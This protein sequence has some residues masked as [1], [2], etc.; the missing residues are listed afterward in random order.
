MKTSQ[1]TAQQYQIAILT[2]RQVRKFTN[3]LRKLGAQIGIDRPVHKQI[4][5][6]D[7]EKIFSALRHSYGW[8][9]LVHSLLVPKLKQ[10]IRHLS[11]N[12]SMQLCKQTEPGADSSECVSLRSFAFYRT[13][14]LV[15][16]ANAKKI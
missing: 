13:G 5:D 3:Y 11:N 1:P 16:T 4:Q 15:P 12:F 2:G 6:T 7:G 9:C 14:S 8:D 10:V